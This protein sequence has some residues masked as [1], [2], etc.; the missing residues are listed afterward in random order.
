M[1]KA[2]QNYSF[3]R[4]WASEVEKKT[5]EYEAINKNAET[6]VRKATPEETLYYTKLIEK[7]KKQNYIKERKIL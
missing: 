1:T 3:R 7:L 2:E 6:I 5:R 4:R